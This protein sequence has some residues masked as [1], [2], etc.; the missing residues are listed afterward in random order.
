MKILIDNGHGRD[1]KGKH[2]PDNPPSLYEWK[3]CRE[4]A[5]D[6]V[7]RLDA[8]GYDV[9]LLTP[10]ESDIPISERVARANAWCKRLGAKNVV[11]VS[12]HNNATGG[13]GQWH[14]ATGFSVYCSKNASDSSHKLAAIFTDLARE[15]R[16]FG[17]RSV[18]YCKYWT[19]SWTTSDIGILKRS[20]CPAVLTENFFQDTRSDV[21]YLL[22]QRGRE[23]VANLHV[24][25]IEK[26]VKAY[27][28]Q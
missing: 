11:L 19:W 6:V 1:T 22:S 26:Y 17:N 20:N 2:S 4:I 25:A 24:D 18:P 9:Q 28:R 5:R 12:V 8:K 13:D 10:E 15:R 16:M 21:A 23:E 7:R 27:G 14:T 3:Y